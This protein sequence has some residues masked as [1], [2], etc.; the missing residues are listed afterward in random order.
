[1]QITSVLLTF[2]SEAVTPVCAHA[3]RLLAEWNIPGNDQIDTWEA[4]TDQQRE[5]D[6]R[7]EFTRNTENGQYGVVLTDSYNLDENVPW[8]VEWGVGFALEDPAATQATEP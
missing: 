3:K 7:K 6:S 1:D 8:C 4:K 2:E 5:V